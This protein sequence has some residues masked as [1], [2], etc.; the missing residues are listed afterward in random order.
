MRDIAVDLA[1]CPNYCPARQQRGGESMNAR[2]IVCRL[3]VAGMI[4]MPYQIAT[5][6]IIDT[7]SA[8]SSERAALASTMAR[9]DV[10]RE[11]QALG[12]DAAVAQERVAMLTDEEART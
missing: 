10:L 4:W 3:L 6:G 8:V 2:R 1:P 11:L 5:A 7:Q 12:V 9:A